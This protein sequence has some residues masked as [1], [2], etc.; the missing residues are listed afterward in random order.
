MKWLLLGIVPY[1]WNRIGNQSVEQM[2][3]KSA[4]WCDKKMIEHLEVHQ[5]LRVNIV[6]VSLA[7]E[8]AL[9]QH[10]EGGFNNFAPRFVS[11]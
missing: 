11:P 9:H 4:P 5:G 3:T 10:R 2:V 6:F 1:P 7:G 8:V